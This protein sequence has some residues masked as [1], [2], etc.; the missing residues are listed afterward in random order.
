MG[1]SAFSLIVFFA[2]TVC[3]CIAFTATHNSRF[4]EKIRIGAKHMYRRNSILCSKQNTSIRSTATYDNDTDNQEKRKKIV[5]IGAGWGGLSAAYALSTS[6]SKN[7]Q[8][9]LR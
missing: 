1:L 2:Q 7:G 9:C 8:A 5:V 4:H 6:K 3:L